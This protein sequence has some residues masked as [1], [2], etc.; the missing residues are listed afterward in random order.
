MLY[1]IDWFKGL[2]SSDVRPGQ[3]LVS[4]D[5]SQVE[6]WDQEGNVIYEAAR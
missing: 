6:I 1:F 5:H 2:P 4:Y 3:L